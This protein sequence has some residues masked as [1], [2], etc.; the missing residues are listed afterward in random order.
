MM[1]DVCGTVS[2]HHTKIIPCLIRLILNMGIRKR[3]HPNI[4][5]TK[6]LL[7]DNT[8]YPYS[9]LFH[10]ILFYSILFHSIP[11]LHYA[12]WSGVKWIELHWVEFNYRTLLDHWDIRH[13]FNRNTSQVNDQDKS[14]A[15]HLS[16]S[17]NKSFML[18]T[19][20]IPTYRLCNQVA[21]SNL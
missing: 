9:I 21:Y 20:Q 12:Q 14:H 4:K 10:S 18:S 6:L 11:F 2:K 7:L 3:V 19:S 5:Y 16:N 1:Y 13:S 15:G 17:M 8:I